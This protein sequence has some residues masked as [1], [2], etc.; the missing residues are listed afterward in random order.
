[1]KV[2]QVQASIARS[3]PSLPPAAF[4]TT[5][6]T[7]VLPHLL[8]VKNQHQQSLDATRLFEDMEAF[9]D[10]AV[11]VCMAA[12]FFVTEEVTIFMALHL[13]L[14][15]IVKIIDSTQSKYSG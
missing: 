1:M 7:L 6:S 9:K 8:Q 3:V 4:A 13:L 2:V 12:R 10:V 15:T 14:K 11:F 5:S